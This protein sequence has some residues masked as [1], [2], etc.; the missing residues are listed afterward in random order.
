[1]YLKSRVKE[2]EVQNYLCFIENYMEEKVPDYFLQ[3]NIFYM[4]G[5]AHI[6]GGSSDCVG[7]FL[8]VEGLDMRSAFFLFVY[9]NICSIPITNTILGIAVIA[10]VRL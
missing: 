10:R 5:V 9:N 1:V 4:Y 7:E 2:D 6:V 3:S 8:W